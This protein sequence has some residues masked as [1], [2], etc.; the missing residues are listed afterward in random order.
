[1]PFQIVLVLFLYKYQKIVVA[2]LNLRLLVEQARPLQNW[3]VG[4]FQFETVL[5]PFQIVNSLMYFPQQ[6]VCVLNL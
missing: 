6:M 4:H 1:M 2:D 3:K 5:V